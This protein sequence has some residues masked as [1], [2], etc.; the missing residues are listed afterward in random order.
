M[1]LHDGDAH[2]VARLEHG[3]GEGLRHDVERFG[4]VAR[5]HDVVPVGRAD[6]LGDAVARHLDGL[7]GLD[8]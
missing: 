5:E 6:E 2:L 1:V 4:R 3:G 7:G 8:R